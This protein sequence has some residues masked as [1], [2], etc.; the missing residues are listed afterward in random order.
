VKPIVDSKTIEAARK[1]AAQAVAA[2]KAGY[3][4]VQQLAKALEKAKERMHDLRVQRDEAREQLKLV[5]EWSVPGLPQENGR[6][7]D[8][9]CEVLN[10][11]AAPPE[12]RE[13]RR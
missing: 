12:P 9:L 6:I 11:H 5:A 4:E 1:K 13:V 3:D 8:A 2:L 7:P 10:F